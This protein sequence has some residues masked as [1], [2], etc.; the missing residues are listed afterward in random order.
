MRNDAVSVPLAASRR[1]LHARDAP[2]PKRFPLIPT[3][4]YMISFTHEREAL[5][6]A[7]L[8]RVSL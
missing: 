1:A 6:E 5:I 7:V 4:Q 8:I 3:M 2:N